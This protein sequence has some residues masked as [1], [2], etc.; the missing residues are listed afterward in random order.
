MDH[1]FLIYNYYRDSF[2]QLKLINY[3]NKYNTLLSL[4]TIGCAKNNVTDHVDFN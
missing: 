2:N 1:S 4:A 3:T